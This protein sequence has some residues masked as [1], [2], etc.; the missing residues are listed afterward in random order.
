VHGTDIDIGFTSYITNSTYKPRALA[1]PAIWA[2]T[3]A[4]TPERT[5]ATKA[6]PLEMEL[7]I[8]IFLTLQMVLVTIIP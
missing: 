2:T 1:T 6:E 5:T 7:V 4:I 8:L 3:G